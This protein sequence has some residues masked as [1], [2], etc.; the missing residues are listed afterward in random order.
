MWQEAWALVSVCPLVVSDTLNISVELYGLPFHSP[1]VHYKIILLN[2]LTYPS[3][4]VPDLSLRQ[5]FCPK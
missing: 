2:I 5:G 4:P 3:A 1:A